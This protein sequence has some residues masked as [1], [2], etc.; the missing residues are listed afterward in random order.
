MLR[1]LEA[2]KDTRLDR[3]TELALGDAEPRV[4]AE[5]RRLLARAKP[6]EGLPRLAQA[7]ESGETVEKQ[8]ALAVLGDLKGEADPVLAAALDRLLAKDYPAELQLDLLEAAAKHPALKEKVAKY[9]AS[10]PRDDHLANYRESLLGG[11]AEAG[12]RVFFNKAEVSCVRCHKVKGEGGDVGPDLAGIG[13]R[14][15]RDYILESIVDPNKQI[16]Q[17]FETVILTLTNGKLVSGIIKGEDANEVKL[18]TAEGQLLTVPKAKI[19][20]RARGKSAMPEDVITHLSKRELRDL[21]EFLANL[22]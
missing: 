7:L 14:Q 8:S 3:A 4:R 15:K 13:S 19:D 18:M 9:E 21:V 6:A 2:L 22:K 1:A 11:D 20:E 10:R 16:A 12:R 17:G 5:G